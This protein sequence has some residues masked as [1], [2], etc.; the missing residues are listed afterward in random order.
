M[1]EEI[2][3]MHD[4]AEQ[5]PGARALSPIAPGGAAIEQA[6]A[7]R[8]RPPRAPGGLLRRERLLRRVAEASSLPLTTLFAPAG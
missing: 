2:S 6:G 8:Y 7:L 4:G 3:A 5:T 1:T